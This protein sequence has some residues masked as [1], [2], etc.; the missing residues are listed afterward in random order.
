[1]QAT[2]SPNLRVKCIIVSAAAAL[3]GSVAL[4]TPAKQV[5]WLPEAA[6]YRLT[7]HYGNLAPVPWEAIAE[8]W[9][10]PYRGAEFPDGAFDRIAENSALSTEA[11]AAAIAAEDRHALFGAATRLLASRI[12]EELDRAIAASS[13][14]AAQ[15]AV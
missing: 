7:L 10:E 11:V 1:M 9:S 6:A 13:P 2:L 15:A 5:P 8:A 3:A 12:G 14:S 4:A